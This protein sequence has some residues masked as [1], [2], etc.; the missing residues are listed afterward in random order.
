LLTLVKVGAL[1]P[2]QSNGLFI[3]YMKE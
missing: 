2:P 1:L 3:M